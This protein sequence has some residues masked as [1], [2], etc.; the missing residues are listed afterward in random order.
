MR[1]E[2]LRNGG[3][4]RG[5]IDFWQVNST[6]TTLKAQSAE[7]KRGGFG[8][9]ISVL[10]N[11]FANI[12]HGDY[13][14]CSIGEIYKATAWVKSPVMEDAAIDAYW[15]DSDLNYIDMWRGYAADGYLADFTLLKAFFPVATEASYMRVAFYNRE[16]FA[17]DYTWY[18]D[19]A[20]LQRMDIDK[21][22]G[23]HDT[24]VDK[25]SLNTLGTFYG[26]V[27]FSGAYTQGEYHLYCHTFTGTSP[28]LDVTIQ[29]YDPYTQEW[30]DVL[31]FQQLIA[32]GDEFKTVLSGLGWLQRVKYVL[33]G[34]AV[35][36]CGFEVGVVYKR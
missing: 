7:K 35:T 25:I 18:I 33:G 6:D 27:Y 15:Y 20:S 32:P 1:T 29:G 14:P 19:G 21:I 11:I 2:L 31:V 23:V 8:G 16:P 22:A 12:L 3:F 5:N 13:I 10:N 17:G 34:T 30:K 4:E 36:N 9:E 26:D 28:T 24:L